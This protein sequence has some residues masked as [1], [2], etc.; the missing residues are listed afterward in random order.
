MPYTDS[1]KSF[2]NELAEK[3]ELGAK[4]GMSGE[5]MKQRAVNIGNWLAREVD[6][7]NYE[8]RLLKELWDVADE[9]EKEVLSGMLFK[10]AREEVPYQRT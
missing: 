9:Q 1:F 2:R 3:I 6:P 10:L 5:Q 7:R 4:V 8:Q